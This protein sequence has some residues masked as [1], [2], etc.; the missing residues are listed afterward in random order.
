MLKNR[1]AKFKPCGILE[2]GVK[3]FNLNPLRAT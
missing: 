3:Y 2:I 1:G